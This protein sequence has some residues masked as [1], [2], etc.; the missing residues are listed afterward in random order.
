MTTGRINQVTGTGPAVDDGACAQCVQPPD[1]LVS[2]MN[3]TNCS[4][5]WATPVTGATPRFPVPGH[6]PE[7]LH[8]PCVDSAGSQGLQSQC[9]YPLHAPPIGTGADPHHLPRAAH[10]ERFAAQANRRT[11]TRGS[12]FY[13]MRSWTDGNHKHAGETLHTTRPYLRK[14]F[15]TRKRGP[16]W[17]SAPKRLYTQASEHLRGAGRGA[18]C[19]RSLA[20]SLASLESPHSA[21]SN[22]AELVAR[23]RRPPAPM[24]ERPEP[25]K[26]SEKGSNKSELVGMNLS[27]S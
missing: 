2:C 8:S 14:I 6:V 5:P 12:C 24:A 16:R 9:P 11:D 15:E 27:G 20:T 4:G 3:A 22:D 10:L 18:A 7:G 13:H 1:L 25:G 21:L 23:D 19:R 26:R 17:L